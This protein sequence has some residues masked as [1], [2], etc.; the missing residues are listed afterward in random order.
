[1]MG[2]HIMDGWDWAWMTTMMVLFWGLVA[3]VVVVALRHSP[4]ET[5]RPTVTPEE[6]LQRRLAAGEIDVNEY[7]ERLNALH[8]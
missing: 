1:M 7:H 4:V 2:R 8:E 6:V 5:R 3:T